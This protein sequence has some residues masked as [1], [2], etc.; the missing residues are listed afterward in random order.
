MIYLCLSIAL[1][2][3]IKSHSS[4][5]RGPRNHAAQC[6][7]ISNRAHFART[8]TYNPQEI[9]QAISIEKYNEVH[10]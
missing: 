10:N 9:S 1:D 6:A 5:S 2:L 8:W 4:M 3:L 7:I